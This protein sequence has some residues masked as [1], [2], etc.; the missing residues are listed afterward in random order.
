MQV[1]HIIN[2]IISS[3]LFI[4]VIAAT[5]YFYNIRNDNRVFGEDLT[6][7]YYSGVFLSI[8]AI[9]GVIASVFGLFVGGNKKKTVAVSAPV[10]ATTYVAAP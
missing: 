7:M 2:L 8:V 3:L 6:F 9:F 5:Y 4:F 10:P 1:V